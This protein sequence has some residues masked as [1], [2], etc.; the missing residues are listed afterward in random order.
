MWISYRY[1]KDIL[2]S[3]EKQIFI[4]IL[5]ISS[6]F[7]NA[8]DIWDKLYR[9]YYKLIN[10]IFPLNSTEK[11]E[12]QKNTKKKLVMTKNKKERRFIYIDITFKPWKKHSRF[13]E[14]NVRLF[15]WTHIILNRAY[16]EKKPYWIFV[17]NIN[18]KDRSYD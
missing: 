8:W 15:S 13:D 17:L 12:K 18:R 2:I 4:F 5:H 6:I 16:T 1:I 14:S 11:W 3:M 9:N 7:L 10:F